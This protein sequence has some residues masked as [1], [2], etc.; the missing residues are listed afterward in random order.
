MVFLTQNDVS[1]NHPGI[2]TT[3]I[4]LRVVSTPHSSGCIF[5]LG[6]QLEVN[7]D[8]VFPVGLYRFLLKVDS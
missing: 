4:L 6:G 3:R 1:E 2:I 5:E 8:V 7:I